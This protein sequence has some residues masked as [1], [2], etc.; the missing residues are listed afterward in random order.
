M[1]NLAFLKNIFIALVC[2]LFIF[3]YHQNKELK[4]NIK[5]LETANARLININKD[6]KQELQKIR[7]NYEKTLKETANAEKKKSITTL[8][9]NKLKTS[10]KNVSSENIV[11]EFN[12][13][14]DKLFKHTA[15]DNNTN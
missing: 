11:C 3:L 8:K 15:N 13:I 9:I 4:Q 6:N 14:L 12:I 10:V 5:E 2:F 1:P 7:A